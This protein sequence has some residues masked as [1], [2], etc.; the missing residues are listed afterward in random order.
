VILSSV[1]LGQVGEEEEKMLLKTEF[2]HFL[3]SISALLFISMQTSSSCKNP[4][5]TFSILMVISIQL[6]TFIL[7]FVLLPLNHSFFEFSFIFC[8]LFERFFEG[9][10]LISSFSLLVLENWENSGFFLIFLSFLVKV[11]YLVGVNSFIIILEGFEFSIIYP[12]AVVIFIFG[13]VT[14]STCIQ[15]LINSRNLEEKDPATWNQI[16]R[17]TVIHIQGFKFNLANLF[18]S[19]FCFFLIIIC[20]EKEE[21]SFSDLKFYKFFGTF[22][23]VFF[24]LMIVFFLLR[25]CLRF[26]IL[27][28]FGMI[29]M[30]TSVI[31]WSF[32]DFKQFQKV[33]F[34]VAL[35]A[36]T[37][38][39]MNAILIIRDIFTN[40]RNQMIFTN[41][42]Q[43]SLKLSAIFYVSFVFA[44]SLAYSL[45]YLNPQVV[46]VYFF[47][48]LAAFCFALA[49]V[50]EIK[51]RGFLEKRELRMFARNSSSIGELVIKGS[52]VQLEDGK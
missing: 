11:C 16:T 44:E 4:I 7:F 6:V 5:T 18:Y 3:G 27:A 39:L 41:Y 28:N 26:R 52:E 20:I 10:W 2:L 37:G 1:K 34:Y 50:A 32:V 35:L 22:I 40:C 38:F 23:G 33:S 42:L 9:V 15:D 49:V 12:L 29:L 31:V 14:C 17:C 43:L 36:T 19:F 45:H 46:K 21:E 25:T 30:G 13:I 47:K 51:N 24:G 8:I 48:V